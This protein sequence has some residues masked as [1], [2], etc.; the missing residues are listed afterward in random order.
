MSIVE[1]VQR[2]TLRAGLALSLFV[3]QVG[4]VMTHTPATPTA[5]ATSSAA[6]I[7]QVNPRGTT[8]QKQPRLTPGAQAAVDA[9]QAD[10]RLYVIV[11]L[12]SPTAVDSKGE[13]VRAAVQPYLELNRP[14]A[15][16]Q[17]GAMIS[18]MQAE[19]GAAQQSLLNALQSPEFQTQ[20][21]HIR[22]FWIFNGVAMRATPAVIRALAERADVESIQVDEWRRWIQ[23]EPAAESITQTAS[24]MLTNSA[25][26]TP[27]KVLSP[28]SM[29]LN[30]SLA[31]AVDPPAPGAVTWGIERIKADQVWNGLGVNGKGITVANIDSGVDWQH[32]A[33]RSRYRGFGNGVA[34]D[35]AHNWM[36]ATDEGSS[37]PV[38]QEAHG[39]HTMGTMVGLN[40]VGVAP[41]AMWMACKGLNGDG[42]GL[43]SW[44][45]ACFQFVLAPNG[46][47]AYAPDIVN[48]S[49]GTDDG[50]NTDFREDVIALRA[51]G[52]LTFF[53][54]GNNGPKQGTVGSPGSFPESIAVGATD[55]EDEVAYFSS[56]GPSPINGAVQPI[57]S[58]PGVRVVST[59]PGGIYKTLSGTS[60][61][62]PH[63][64][65]AAALLLSAKPSMDIATTLY[66]L[67]S[68]ARALSSTIPNNDS[69]YGRID[70][71][72]AVLSVLET[73]V[74]SGT[75]YE[76]NGAPIAGALV[77]ATGTSDAGILQ[78]ITTTDAAGHYVM[79][80]PFGMYTTTAGAF[81]FNVSAPGSPRLVVAK[82]VVVFDMNLVELPTAVVR[83]R[84][85]N[86]FNNEAVTATVTALG[87]P[88]Q[89]LSTNGC[90]PCRYSLDLPAGDYTLEARALGY[91]VQTRTLSLLVGTVVDVDFSLTPTQKIAFV[92]SGA[93]YYG[94]QAHF[95]RE[96][97]DALHLAY[98]EYR[99]K[100]IPRDTP[101]I[102]QLLSYDTVIWSS[103]YDSPGLVNAG[104]TIS[105]Y[106]SAGKNLMLTGQD[107]AFYD[108]GGTTTFEDYFT[109][110]IGAYIDADSSSSD[111]IQGAPNT[112]L[113]G[114]AL[115]ITG[116]D[117]A[118]NQEFPDVVGLLNPDM[119]KLIGT[120]HSE[121]ETDPNG[122]G[123][124]ADVC[125]DH[126]V[127]F[128][129]FGFEAINSLAD[130]VDVLSRTLSA[131]AQPRP[132][133]G[134]DLISRDN[135][136]RKSAIGLPGSVV[137]HVVRVRN[138][139]RANYSSNI[140]LSLSG[141]HWPT[142]L[143][144]SFLT[145]KPCAS[146]LV[147]L[148]VSIPPTVT[149]NEGDDI[150][151]TALAELPIGA[152]IGPGAATTATVSLSFLSK[153][154]ASIMLVDDERFSKS[155]VKYLEAL[156]SAG[157]LSVDRWDTRQG[158][159][160]ASS[161]PITALNQYS[162]VI[163]YN[164]YDW[165]DPVSVAEQSVL[166]QYLLNGGRLFLSSQSMLQYTDA[167]PF[168][169]QFL[170]LGTLD[171]NEVITGIIGAPGSLIGNG[172]A[173]D[174]MLPFPYNWN[175]STPVQPMSGTQVMLHSISGQPAGLAQ[176]GIL[177]PGS[178][179]QP[180][181]WKTV[182]LPF[183][184]ETLGTTARIDVM[185]RVVGWLSWLGDSTLTAST[186]TTSVGSHVMYT[187]TLRADANMP[188]SP[189][190]TVA[191]SVPVAPGLQVVASTLAGFS[192]GNAGSWSGVIKPG[193]VM[194]WQFEA[195]VT[196][197]PVT[198]SPTGIGDPLT[199]TL[200]V[201]LAPAQLH[202]TRPTMVY[203]NAPQ[204]EARYSIDPALPRWGG[205][206]RLK[207]VVRNT[208]NVPADM[209]QL[210]VTVPTGL[211]PGSPAN[212]V[213]VLNNAAPIPSTVDTS[214]V[215][216]QGQQISWQGSLKAGG[217]LEMTYPISIPRFSIRQPL[218]FFNT[219]RIE[220]GG[221]TTHAEIWLVPET[222]LFRFPI[223]M[224]N[225]KP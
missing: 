218:A 212:I 150:V 122:A 167:N 177:R 79:Q 161:P 184:F 95:F 211:V 92:D 152:D 40:G 183:A 2:C 164:G 66:T 37:Y 126:K 134:V 25:L 70:V 97:L 116:G 169:H 100:Q 180:A 130:R 82:H 213:L 220:V 223:L 124:Y 49:W 84:V 12:N 225:G 120:Y 204:L 128:Y 127:A 75:V 153:T 54:S 106:L 89:S 186:A 181:Q 158:I 107:V 149:A 59:V 91:E 133:I 56:R 195:L 55:T 76:L 140:R 207:L 157:N 173:A 210:T 192:A 104:K 30:S 99:I 8:Q 178:T 27:S 46:D 144:T 168:S 32:P 53:S 17:R 117:G 155:E 19:A 67:T 139:A 87:T 179:Q 182:F 108:A 123:V 6:P 38:D 110:K 175:L 85:K 132:N 47:P 209:L 20:T 197:P 163:W 74:I 81:G 154:P 36:D 199:A 219:A 98:D 214:G 52:I 109:E 14:A 190:Q 118:N 101:T 112:L 11:R 48:N 39:T 78:S 191:I 217:E 138:T 159:G 41:G 94:S 194:T 60:M 172:V 18:A 103:P 146:A 51:A 136:Y 170:G 156:A 15:I 1:T 88:K 63:V 9:A 77:T 115:T 224:R 196:P 185:N 160:L 29:T 188:N 43:N 10:D 111:Q 208:G 4:V 16:A 34:F 68:T 176:A 45:H 206:A 5:A 148:T 141:H 7:S 131:F 222:L 125:V 42:Y 142:Q 171:F 69:G 61:A 80:V 113:A 216:A 145:L 57:V 105:A 189:T 202:W 21:D 187:L 119:G 162:V 72:A 135:F 28:I 83:G 3:V 23:S 73:G 58:A 129:S 31:T 166:R 50:K 33:L 200:S 147:T 35:H 215:V 203:L 24:L 13:A 102:T 114:K 65:G 205:S 62:S 193:D 165:F 93:W 151:L 198:Q 71:Y 143:S 26:V 64:A 174:T 22:S 90:P 201:A 44:L 96:S 121:I 221:M 86:A 137:T